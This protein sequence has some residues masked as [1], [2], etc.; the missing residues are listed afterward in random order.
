MRI[1]CLALAL[2]ITPAMATAQHER[3]GRPDSRSRGEHS[4]QADPPPRREHTRPPD[5][6]PSSIGSIGLPLPSIGLPLSPIGLQPVPNGVQ[7]VPGANRGPDHPAYAPGR[8][9]HSRPFVFVSPYYYADGIAS[10]MAPEPPVSGVTVFTPEVQV[11]RLRLDIQ[12]AAQWQLFVDGLFVG[13]PEDLG[14][15]V[16]LE[17]G[18]RH[19]EIRAP[20][21][22][23]LLFDARIDPRRVITYRGKLD[24]I[25]RVPREAPA[26]RRETPTAPPAAVATGNRTIYVIPGCYLGNVM[27]QKEKLREGCDLG[28]MKTITP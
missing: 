12:P 3:Q 2:L 25:A 16:D 22:E 21:Y 26:A 20:G 18:P 13:T 1:L 10:S 5:P 9:G 23:S 11:G 15:E 24:P 27:P 17:A 7:P 4:K 6:P 8:R 14:N 28:S 19:I